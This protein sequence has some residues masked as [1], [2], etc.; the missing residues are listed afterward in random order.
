M[1]IREIRVKVSQIAYGRSGH[2]YKRNREE[3]RR[4]SR[5]VG[6]ISGY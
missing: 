6:N 5:L 4:L 3:R 1:I 2:R